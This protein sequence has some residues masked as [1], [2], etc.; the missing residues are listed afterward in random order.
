[1]TFTVRRLLCGHRAWFRDLY[2]N[3]YDNFGDYLRIP[4]SSR[5]ITL[6]NDA[7]ETILLV[8]DR[9][10]PHLM[11]FHQFERFLHIVFGPASEDLRS[12]Y[13]T[14]TCGLRVA[15]F[16]DN[17]QGQI[18]ISN[19]AHEPLRFLAL[20]YQNGANIP[21]PHQ[22]RGALSAVNRHAAERIFGHDV[23]ASSLH[24]SLLFL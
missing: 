21:I 5:N 9:N 14:D 15:F 8:H 4:Q 13:V 23:L 3:F 20:A 2:D 17:S 22:L 6:R 18:S 16:G 19:D 24:V 7:R 12:H 1:V 10:A 11:P